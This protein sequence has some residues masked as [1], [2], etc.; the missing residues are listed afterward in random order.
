MSKCPER[1]G[2]PQPAGLLDCESVGEQP[3]NGA[4]KLVGAG[5]QGVQPAQRGR[6]GTPCRR[7]RSAGHGRLEQDPGHGMLGGPE[8]GHLIET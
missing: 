6:H 2:Q 1:S 7:P 8:H 3:G 5:P 4:L